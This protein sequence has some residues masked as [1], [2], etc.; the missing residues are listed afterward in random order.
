MSK[1]PEVINPAQQGTPYVLPI[2]D[3]MVDRAIASCQ[4]A[5]ATQVASNYWNS[6]KGLVIAIREAEQR[7]KL[8]EFVKT[9]EKE[10]DR[11]RVSHGYTLADDCSRA[12]QRDQYLLEQGLKLMDMCF[13]VL[14][15][16][17]YFIRRG[18]QV[19]SNVR[20]S[21]LYETSP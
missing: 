4:M 2:F 19:Q 21:Q 7:K 11:R 3:T 17:G 18:K 10:I 16:G 14:D 15:Q 13:T 6:L 1:E 9:T 5:Y 8:D 20:T 12:I